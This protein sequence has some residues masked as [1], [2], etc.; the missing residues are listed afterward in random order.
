MKT[1]YINI[2]FTTTN[3]I[4]IWEQKRNNEIVMRKED[5]ISS[6]INHFV[7]KQSVTLETLYNTICENMKLFI[8]MKEMYHKVVEDMIKKD[9]IKYKD[10]LLVK[11]VY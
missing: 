9:Y 7:K 4:D 6:L 1:D 2:F 10:N 11:L 5:I 8:I 3:Y